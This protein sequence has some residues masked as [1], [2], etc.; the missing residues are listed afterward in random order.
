MTIAERV[1]R[2]RRILRSAAIAA[3]VMR[4]A[5]VSLAF[6]LL[7]ATA[8]AFVP[9]PSEARRLVP[10]VA[11]IGAVLVFARRIK[12]SGVRSDAGSA[13]LWIEARFPSLRYALVTAV[14]PRYAG[15]VPDVER[16]AAEVVFE[17]A[18]TRAVRRAITGPA[19][20]VVV[21]ALVLLVLPSGA[22]A[23]VVTP[24]VGDALNR[25][26][27]GSH[28]N[29][30]AIVVVR[31]TPPA[32]AGMKAESF[33]NPAS[34]R[35][36]VGSAVTIE[37]VSGEGTVV[38]TLSEHATPATPS[39]D[40][41]SLALVMPA[42]PAAVRFRAAAHERL[43]VLEPVPDSAPVVVLT[44]PARDSILRTP[45][46][47]VSLAASASDDHGL[48]SGAFELIVSTGGGENFKFKSSTLGAATFS[49]RS[50][51]LAATISL[52]S[53]GLQPG[54]MLHLRAVVR[55][56]NDVTGPGIGASD[57]RTLRI[58][59]ADEYDS[60]AVDPAPPP[61]A[62][63]NALSQRMLLLMAQALE[64]KRPK[65][66]HGTLVN[67]SRGI[68][69]DQTRLRKR[70]GE[71]V[72]TRLGE[73]TGEEG[74]ALEKRLDQPV[75]PDSVLAAADR[76]ASAAVG[77]ALEGNEDETPLV[78][79]N[80]PLLE[81]Y[82]AMWSASSELEVGEPGKAIPF[83]KRALDALQAARSAE[84]IYL[85]GK[86]RAVVVD[87]DRVRLQGKDK[88]TPAARTPR[89]AADP[90]RDRRIAR[91]DAVLGLVKTA[92]SAA[93]DSLLL[94][95]LDLLDR[96]MAAANAIEAA[97]NALR[98][99]RDATA[100]LIRAR[101]SLASV[102]PAPVALSAWGSPP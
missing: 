41:W 23:R 59:R 85:R 8:D 25:A 44:L 60:V 74:N 1:E 78:A 42:V 92:P 22:V 2:A 11:I 76:A 64:Q 32:Y 37:G 84:R 39:G 3:A 47:K 6:L 81:A 72:F 35:A 62:E 54:D 90:A 83:M 68:A 34:V 57:T 56:R 7:A 79:V 101:R 46:G 28:A 31:V 10:V 70:V 71:I 99:G 87:I 94:L 38:A 53:L 27:N 18:V 20:A 58:A 66:S 24:S 97:A 26:R 36:L 51:E 30:L 82:N 75:N 4:G 12:R 21:F 40:R 48:A 73:D 96:D 14:D 52:D 88:G 50:G 9:L 102:S 43:L 16:A 80:R 100:A 55:D 98:G 33:D 89:Q 67:E 19:V 17:P 77:T 15:R 49:S 13:A 65:T 69:V 29:P 63:K 61:E 93:V 86:T 5:A 95:R 45:G 91:F